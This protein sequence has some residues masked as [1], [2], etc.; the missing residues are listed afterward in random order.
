LTSRRRAG[1][2]GVALALAVGLVPASAFPALAQEGAEP[3]TIRLRHQTPWIHEGEPLLLSL[4]ID[5]GVPE[6]GSIDLTLFGALES[7]DALAAATVD[8]STLGGVR[9]T[10]SIPAALMLRGDDGAYHVRLATD[11]TGAGLQVDDP[12]VYPLAVAVTPPEGTPGTPLV[13]FV[14]RVD[15]DD[16]SRLSTALVL[17]IHAAPSISPDGTPSNTEV[18]QRRT[19]VRTALLER[20]RRVAVTV[21]PTPETLEAVGRDN[22]DLLARF[23]RAVSN[24][25]VIGGPYVRLDVAAWA[26]SPDLVAA[27]DDQVAAGDAALQAALHRRV[28]TRT[29]VVPGNATTGAIELLADHGVDQAVF[30]QEAVL[31][32]DGPP[33]VTEPVVVMGGTGLTVLTDPTLRGHAN[34]TEDP[35]RAAHVLLADLALIGQA[36]EDGGVV[37]ELSATRPLPASFL[38]AVFKGLNEPGPLTSVTVNGLFGADPAGAEGPEPGPTLAAA[39]AASQDLS[40]YGRNLAVSRLTV[41]GYASFAGRD[42]PVVANLQRRLLASGA[43]DLSSTQRAA[44]LAEVSHTIQDHTSQVTVTDEDVTL[45]S[46]EGDIP[47]TVHNDTDGP[48]EVELAFDSD[49][50][51]EFP[52]GSHQ[53]LRLDQGANRLEV[54]VVARTSGSFPLRITVTSPDG[55]LTVTRAR[56]TVRS[57]AWSGVGV[58]LSVGAGLVLFVWWARHWRTAR[59]NKRLV[60]RNPSGDAPV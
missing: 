34:D 9:D 1:L 37:V 15:D 38:G 30:R 23:R 53:R 55:V 39:R 13:T 45:T 27:A 56:L 17:P 41:G 16:P 3:P 6:G 4:E 18:A 51:L 19:E 22:P 33:P 5:G 12:G 54:Q 7:R 58:V 10:L 47:L 25:H 35:V 29:W 46:R 26:A 42:D 36:V 24:R 43:T 59:R 60:A 20:Y 28:D 14:V 48:V 2:A 21:A 31:S 40:A 49:N 11:G 52:D 8:P 44:Y 50:R 32:P 57:T